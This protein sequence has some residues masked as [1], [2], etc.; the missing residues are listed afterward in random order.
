M[1]SDNLQ[2]PDDLTRRTL[3]IL[4][5][6]M[7]IAG[8]LWTLMPFGDLPR[9]GSNWPL[10]VPRHSPKQSGRSFDPRLLGFCRSPGENAR[11]AGLL[12]AA[13][14]APSGSP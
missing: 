7:L 4:I 6:L 13:R 8:S 14:L 12:G 2:A 3:L 1:P 10:G 11:P 5:I 9:S